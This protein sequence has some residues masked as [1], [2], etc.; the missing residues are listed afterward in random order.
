MNNY[1]AYIRFTWVLAVFVFLVILAGSVVRMTQSGMGCPD[2]P[3]CFGRWIPPTNASQLPPDFE[4][5]LKLQDIDHTFN[6]YH[7][8]VEY[9]N[10]LCTA[11]LGL[12]M[13]IHVVWSYKKFFATRRNIFWLSLSFL[14]LTA[15]EAWLGKV[16]VDTNLSVVKITLH[17]LLALLIAA[18]AIIIISQLDGAEKIDRKRMKWVANIALVVLLIQIIIGTDVREQ[19]DEISKSFNYQF[20]NLWI[21]QLDKVFIIHRSFSWVV[22][23]LCVTIM[24]QS[25]K[26]PSLKKQGIFIA[27]LVLCLISIG[28][29]MA[30]GNIPA[31]VQPMHI[32]LS[33][34]LFISL[35]YYRLKF[36]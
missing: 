12:W 23:I 9:I 1:K 30:Y 10:R 34:I 19:I 7:T 29:I 20:R 5:Y 8:W 6:V 11:L 26:I 28:V 31:V 17:M 18:V 22:A 35:L 13:M 16:V 33:S 36:K 24:I 25:N 3:T 4:K 27:L 2:W 21:G 14:L 15:F 32:L